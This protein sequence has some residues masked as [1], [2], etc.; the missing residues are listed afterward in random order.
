[1]TFERK[2]L[3]RLFYELTALDG[4]IGVL[5][6]VG[7]KIPRSQRAALQRVVREMRDECKR[8]GEE[9]KS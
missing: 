1:M 7:V 8:H 2:H 4:R 5:M 3:R 6:G 9:A